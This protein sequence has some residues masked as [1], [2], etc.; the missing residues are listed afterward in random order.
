MKIL[1]TAAG[2]ARS[3][4]LVDS[5]AQSHEIRLTERAPVETEHEVAPH[6][7]ARIEF[8]QCGLGHD[9]STNLL[10]RGMDAIIHAVD[11]MPGEG[12]SA[13][14]DA[15]PR[16]TYNLL[17]AAAEEG[18]PQ[19]VL[20]STLELMADYP[21]GYRVDE[22]WR[23]LPRTQPPTLSAHL[24]EQISREFARERKL[25]VTILRLGNASIETVAAAVNEALTSANDWQIT[26]IG[27]RAL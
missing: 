2:A 8:V 25:A 16:C 7:S 20:L 22:R 15:A 10:V 27:E 5:L 24:A 4:A 19:I 18:V 14:I 12:E 26:H 11:P 3:A 13:Q 9:R 1:L 23:P 17:M 21:D 6:S